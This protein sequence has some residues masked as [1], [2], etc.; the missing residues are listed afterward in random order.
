MLKSK[1]KIQKGAAVVYREVEGLAFGNI[2]LFFVGVTLAGVGGQHTLFLSD[3][4]PPPPPSLSRARALCLST[5]LLFR[6]YRRRRIEYLRLLLLMCSHCVHVAVYIVS[7]QEKKANQDSVGGEG[8][9]DEGDD[10]IYIRMIHTYVCVY[11]CVCVF[12]CVYMYIY[13]YN[14]GD[15]EEASGGQRIKRIKQGESRRLVE[16]DHLGLSLS[17]SLSLSFFVF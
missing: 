5:A 13:T 12:A 17:L 8:D 9:V 15:D 11:V 14:I 16:M 7:F 10:Y 3:P 4:P 2:M 1:I 6:S